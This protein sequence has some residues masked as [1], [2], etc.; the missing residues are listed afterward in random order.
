[1]CI[2]LWLTLLSQTV[3][4]ELTGTWEHEAAVAIDGSNT[5][6][7]KFESIIVPELSVPLSNNIDMTVIARLRLDTYDELGYKGERLSSDSSINAPLSEGSHRDMSIREWH[8]DTEIFNTYWRIGKQQ[9]VWGQADGLKVLDVVNPQS[10]REFILDK[11]ADS[12]TPLWMLNVEVPVGDNDSLQLLWIP[13]T[14][15]NELAI[16]GSVYEF[17]SAL[18]VPQQIEGTTLIDINVDKPSGAG[19]GDIGLRY[20]KFSSGWDL[21]FNYLYHFHD[22]P[23]FYQRVDGNNVTIDAK[24]KRNHLLGATAS[25]AF[26]SFILRAEAGYSSDTYHLLNNTSPDF[27]ENTGVHP[28]DEF[29]S[30]IGLDYQGIENTLLSMQWFQSTLFDYNHDLVRPERNHIVSWL[31]RQYFHNE[32]WELEILALYGLDKKESLFQAE[33]SYMLE[34]N[35]KVWIGADVISGPRESLFGQ[36]DHTD[37]FLFGVEWGY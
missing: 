18:I 19:K 33:L 36:F 31:Y 8:F 27:V 34:S 7:Q 2:I 16:A 5:A 37:R 12:R 17:T 28:S 6:G 32:T 21:T 14:T 29:S 1:M 13:D 20:S 25:K 30:V 10:Y 26:G 35:I 24:Y 3:C 15:Y 22:N 4:A 9:V 23:V 11:F